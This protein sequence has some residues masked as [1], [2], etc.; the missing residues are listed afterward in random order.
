MSILTKQENLVLENLADAYIN[1]AQLDT[2]HPADRR[3]FEDAVHRAQNIVMS[4]PAMRAFI[5]GNK[6]NEI[7][8]D[9]NSEL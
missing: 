8:L 6:Y 1:F 2:L 3:E 7:G 4:R 5:A 9:N